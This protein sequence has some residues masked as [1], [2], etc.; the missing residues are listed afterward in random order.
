MT[1]LFEKIKLLFLYK[2]SW[3]RKRCYLCKPIYINVDRSAKI[4]VSD[5]FRFNISWDGHR[6]PFSGSFCLAR[7]AAL[8]VSCFRAYN[9]C[10]IAV[11][12]N[13]E[14]TLGNSMM[15]MNSSIT[16]FCS[17]Q[18]GD[19]VLISE[20]VAIRDSDNHHLLGSV[21]T[22][23]IVICDHVWIGMNST[24]LKGVTIGEGAVIAAGAVVTHDV[25]PHT[26]VGGVPARVIREN[27][28]F[29]R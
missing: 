25:P 29:E 13:A 17:I 1:K 19:D 11:N 23:P 18:I 4:E 8:K 15:N 26:L 16:C 12:E 2:L 27:I 14:L 3:L 21:V 5:S 7:N 22:A 20:N 6:Q 24:I 9:G 10:R 28:Q